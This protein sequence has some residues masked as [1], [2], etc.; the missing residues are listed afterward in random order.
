[1]ST[2]ITHPPLFYFLI[3]LVFFQ[4]VSGLYGGSMLIIDSTGQSLELPLNLLNDTPFDDYL[5]PGTI[6]LLILGVF[7][8]IV[9]YGLWRRYTWAWTGALIVSLALIIWIGVQISMIGYRAQPPLQAIY[10]ALGLIMLFTL[11][12]SG[13][14][15]I[16]KTKG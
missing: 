7:P 9:A 16:F 4:G 3:V 8:T 13:C 10:G 15:K 12:G 2:K 1:M 14:R 5:M 6:L 11:F